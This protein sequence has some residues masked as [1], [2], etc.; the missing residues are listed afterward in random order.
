MH[1]SKVPFFMPEFSSSNIILHLF[2]IDNNEGESGIV[3]VTIIGH[4]LVVQLGLLSKFKY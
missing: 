3:Y 1:D 4:N 2:H